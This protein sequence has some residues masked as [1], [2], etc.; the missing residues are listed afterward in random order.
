[1][2]DYYVKGRIEG[3]E[4]AFAYAETTLAVNEIVLMQDC[5]PVAAHLLGR[6]ITATV[7]GASLL[8]VSQRL[9]VNWKYPGALDTLY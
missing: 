5:D 3:L 4:I 9:N 1:M 6:A 7:L 2:E 8:P